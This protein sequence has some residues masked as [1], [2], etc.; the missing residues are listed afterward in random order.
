MSID[1]SKQSCIICQHYYDVQENSLHDKQQ[2]LTAKGYFHTSISD[3]K[4]HL[5]FK[6]IQEEEKG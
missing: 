2:L 6:K 5:F 4:Q 3:I 1:I